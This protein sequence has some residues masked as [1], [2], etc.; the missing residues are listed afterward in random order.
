MRFTV[1]LLVGVFLCGPVFAEGACYSDQEFE[2]DR[3]LRLQ[4]D[5]EVIT[6][7]CRYSSHGEN[8]QKI[9]YGSFLRKHGKQV[10]SW[11]NTIARV[12]GGGRNETID[13]FKT[14]LANQKGNESATM[15]PRK[16]CAQWADFVPYAASLTD[17]QMMYYV[18]QEDAARPT[19]KPHC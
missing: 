5:L 12:Y 3:G 1:A 10:H 13:N 19:K 2:A 14:S 17:A 15:G 6:L 4:T 11:E 9:Y 7:T 8:L 18:R 16:F